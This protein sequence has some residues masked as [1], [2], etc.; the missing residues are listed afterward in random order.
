VA[1]VTTITLPDRLH[2]R[3][4]SV[5]AKT[6][7]SMAAVVRDALERDDAAAAPPARGG[8]AG[9]TRRAPSPPRSVMAWLRAPVGSYRLLAPDAETAP[10]DWDPDAEG[11]GLDAD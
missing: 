9:A 4:R 7:R 11:S 6:G 10:T 2:E 1:R 8:R 3:I 5:G